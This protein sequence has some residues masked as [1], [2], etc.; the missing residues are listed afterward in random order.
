[1]CVW[2][3]GGADQG[4]YDTWGDGRL[5]Q[6]QQAALV[7][8]WRSKWRER[9]NGSTN[10]SFPF[11]WVQLNSKGTPPST[12]YTADY[13]SAN[14]WRRGDPIGAYRPGFTGVRWAQT[15]ALRDVAGTFMAVSLDT[16]AIDGSVHSPFKQ[17]V[18]SRM[19]RS[20]LSSA[21]GVPNII[22]QPTATVERV[23]GMVL[24]TVRSGVDGVGAVPISVRSNRG[25][26]A[27]APD[28]DWHWTP[29]VGIDFAAGEYCI[30]I[31]RKANSQPTPA[32]P[33]RHTPPRTHPSS[34][35]LTP[36]SLCGTLRT[37]HCA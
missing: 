13:T 20:A 18:G 10:A 35:I 9:T 6:C 19:A 4:E 28:N 31:A 15:N 16:P 22:S 27:L 2:G 17:P 37:H 8:D 25:F 32:P 36:S 24:V 7:R 5:Y 30:E 1:M 23:A 3:G 14:A 11:G 33:P 34:E 29:I 21:Y 12:L 26:E